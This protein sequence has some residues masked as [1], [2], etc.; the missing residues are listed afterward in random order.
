MYGR[1]PRAYLLA[2]ARKPTGEE[3]QSA[4]AALDRIIA[5]WEKQ[6]EKDKPAEPVRSRARW[7]AL[8]TVCHTLI[9]S[10]EFLY[11]D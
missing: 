7:L 1:A 5:D 4:K 8:A 3:A 9:N 11:I 10:A 6:L 2:F